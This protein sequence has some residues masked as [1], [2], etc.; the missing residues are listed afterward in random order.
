MDDN[1]SNQNNNFFDENFCIKC[2]DL[3][4]GQ[5]ELSVV[6]RGLDK[7]IQYSDFKMR[8]LLPLY[9][10]DSEKNGVTVKIQLDQKTITNEMKLRGDTAPTIS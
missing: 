6:T 4:S 3:K 5:E 8:D 7:L 10:S 9:L 2:C 1:N